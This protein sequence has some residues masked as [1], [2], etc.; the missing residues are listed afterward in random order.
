MS[1]PKIVSS[2]NSP[3]VL[4]FA[5]SIAFMRAK[6]RWSFILTNVS[7]VGCASPN[8][9]LDAISPDTEPGMEQ[10]V[11]FN[12]KFSEVWPVIVSQKEPMP[13]ADERDG[14]PDKMN[15]YFSEKPGEGG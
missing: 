10:W 11:E 4:R 13:N 3:T 1:S 14:E 6:I 8:A 12:R 15:K 2:V 5:R 9:R 7:I